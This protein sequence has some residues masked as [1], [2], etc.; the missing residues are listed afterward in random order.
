MI[1]RRPRRMPR[2][3][4]DQRRRGSSRLAC[5]S[6]FVP[7]L[8]CE[9]RT[10]ELTDLILPPGQSRFSLEQLQDA[11]ADATILSYHESPTAGVLQ[12]RLIEHV[13]TSY[14]RNILA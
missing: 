13:R 4:R 1:L 14:R 10:Y 8:P 6:R 5:Q 3:N 7:P 11:G 9:S 2:P 12:K